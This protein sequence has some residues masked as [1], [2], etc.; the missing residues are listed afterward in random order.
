MPVPLWRGGFSSSSTSFNFFRPGEI[1]LLYGL[2]DYDFYRL[3]KMYYS[4]SVGNFREALEDLYCVEEITGKAKF[5]LTFSLCLY[6]LVRF[7]FFP[8]DT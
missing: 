6:I 5:F 4:L 3:Y 1:G 8:L 7:F 2:N